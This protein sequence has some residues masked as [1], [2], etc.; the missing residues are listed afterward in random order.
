MIL[1][2]FWSS[3]SLMFSLNST[4]RGL[5]GSWYW[6]H[7]ILTLLHITGPCHK[8]KNSHTK[9]KKK[10]FHIGTFI[11]VLVQKFVEKS[12][13]KFKQLSISVHS[14]SHFKDKHNYN[15]NSFIP[16]IYTFFCQFFTYFFIVKHILKWT[17]F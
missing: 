9:S 4:S 8:K 15:I 3:S 6:T 11:L 16:K 14:V 13:K 1:F 17:S 7:S 5:L 2:L 12:V 10:N